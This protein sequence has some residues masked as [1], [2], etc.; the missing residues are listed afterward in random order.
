MALAVSE[1]LSDHCHARLQSPSHTRFTACISLS[2]CTDTLDR[3][4]RHHASS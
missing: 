2:T 4:S 1:A 3:Y